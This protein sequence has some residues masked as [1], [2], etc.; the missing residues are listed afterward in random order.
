MWAPPGSKPV[1]VM[2]TISCCPCFVNVASPR[3]PLPFRGLSVTL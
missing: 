1:A 3:A 2:W